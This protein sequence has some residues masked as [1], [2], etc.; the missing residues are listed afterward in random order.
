MGRIV[1]TDT[2]L[3][4]YVTAGN[5]IFTLYSTKTD[6]RITYKVQQDHNNR[7]RYFVKYLYGPENTSDYRY[8]GMFYKDTCQLY[9][10]KKSDH[11][12]S[13]AFAMMHHFLLMISGQALW[14]DTCK[15][16][17]SDRCA[18]CGRLLTTPESIER[19]LGPECA[20]LHN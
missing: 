6:T 11:S 20:Q 3:V 18:R 16:Y 2:K 13:S 7:H 1:I 8:L 15:V 12:S 4:E 17:K 19:G 9:Y 14:R 5:A 10:T